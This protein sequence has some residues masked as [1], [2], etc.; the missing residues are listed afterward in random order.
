MDYRYFPEPDLLPLVLDK[1]F[2]EERKIKELPIDRR[3]KYLQV[4]NLQEDDSRILSEKKE[5][6][7]YFEELVK[8]TND[9]KKSCAYITTVLLAHFKNTEEDINFFNLKFEIKEFAEIINLINKNELSS[10][11]AKIVLE[12]LF[13]N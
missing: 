6:S 4:F 8:L 9:P 10:T 5:I 7:D 11:N 1:N 3:I 12:E 2:I 13:T